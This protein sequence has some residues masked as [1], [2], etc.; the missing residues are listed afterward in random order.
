MSSWGDSWYNSWLDSWGSVTTDPNA[1]FGSTTV[2]IT[3]TGTL[4]S[5]AA[6]GSASITI[7]ATGELTAFGQKKKSGSNA[8][9]KKILQDDEEI[10]LCIQAFF[11]IPFNI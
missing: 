5:G 2:R 7:T 1:M 9:R 4:E 10:V 3:A 6:T 11:S 8:H